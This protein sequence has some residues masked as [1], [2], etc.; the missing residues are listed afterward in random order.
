MTEEVSGCICPEC[1]SNYICE[2][3]LIESDGL[4]IIDMKFKCG[5]E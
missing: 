2:S 3:S 1:D 4:S 5:C